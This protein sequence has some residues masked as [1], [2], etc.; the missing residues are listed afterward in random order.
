MSNRKVKLYIAASIDGYIARPDGSLDWLEGLPNPN[1]IDYGYHAFYKTI[2]TVIMGRI[3]YEEVLSFDVDWPYANGKTYVVSS[4]RAL[5][6]KTKNTWLIPED[7]V[8]KVTMIKD[9]EGKDI[10]LLGGGKLVTTFLNADLIDE[11]ILFITPVILG[12]GIPLF[13]D[14]PKEATFELVEAKA[15]ETGMTGL[16]YRRG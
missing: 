8:N 13:P 16:T 10:W 15:Y 4:D 11:M 2:D 12:E 7:L 5:N 1:K 3:T 9:E 14:K 6:I